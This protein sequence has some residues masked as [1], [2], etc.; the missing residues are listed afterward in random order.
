MK[1]TKNSDSLEGCGADPKGI[2]SGVYNFHVRQCLTWSYMEIM[3][4]SPTVTISLPRSMIEMIDIMAND[5]YITR[6]QFI[7]DILHKYLETIEIIQP[8]F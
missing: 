4:V 2:S 5:R 6:S 7:R 8:D 3:R 1:N